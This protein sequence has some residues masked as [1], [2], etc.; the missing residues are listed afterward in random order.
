MV[1][2][3][4]SSNGRYSRVFKPIDLG[5][6]VVPN[7]IF[8][9][10]HGIPLE[11][12]SK[13]GDVSAEPAINRAYYF[14][15][16]AAGG[17]GLILHSTQIMSSQ[18]NLAESPYLEASIPAYQRVAD[19][20]HRHGA[21][22]FAQIWYVNWV[23]KAWEK[24]GPEAPAMAPSALPNLYFPG[25]RRAMSHREIDLMISTYATSARH[26]RQSGYDGIELH[27][28]HGSIVERSEER[29][30]GKECRSRWSPHH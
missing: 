24:L 7:R 13:G 6:V 27:I 28:S 14:G 19:E 16:R 5:P 1:D 22:I 15:E 11:V 4:H 30:V 2:R 12:K 3:M 10:P 9:S 20:V 17:T 21:K 23:Q 29:R 25:V 8:M 18:T 26:L